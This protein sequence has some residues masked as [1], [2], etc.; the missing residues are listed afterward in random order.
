MVL[1]SLI[2]LMAIIDISLLIFS[3]LEN[4]MVQ[5]N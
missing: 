1:F 3:V 4:E 5:K 2:K